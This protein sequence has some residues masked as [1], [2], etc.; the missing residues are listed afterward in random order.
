ML[1]SV[2]KLPVVELCRGRQQ[3]NNRNVLNCQ[4]LIYIYVSDGYEMNH[5]S[6]GN[7]IK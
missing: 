7:E 5:M 1:P 2:G 4:T 6:C 3:Q